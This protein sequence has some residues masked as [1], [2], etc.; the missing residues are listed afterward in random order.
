MSNQERKSTSG[1]LS[2]RGEPGLVSGPLDETLTIHSRTL[3]E[4]ELRS[5]PCASGSFPAPALGAVPPKQR[6]SHHLVRDDRVDPLTIEELSMIVS[7]AP[8]NCRCLILTISRC[9]RLS[10]T[11]CVNFEWQIAPPI[12]PAPFRRGRRNDQRNPVPAKVG[13]T[14]VS[15]IPAFSG[16]SW[17]GSRCSA[18]QARTSETENFRCLPNRY[19]AGPVPWTRQP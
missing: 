8:S 3:S 13:A 7:I 17:N 4:A 10:P 18:T 6:D 12:S 2:E 14:H 1:G 15:S 16:I 9:S 19:A 5:V 11:I